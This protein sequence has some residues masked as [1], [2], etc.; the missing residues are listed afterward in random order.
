MIELEEFEIGLLYK[1]LVILKEKEET[2]VTIETD[3]EANPELPT[4]QEE[5][6]PIAEQ[7]DE[8]AL[9]SKLLIFPSAIEQELLSEQSNF[10][11]ILTALKSSHIVTHCLRIEDLKS[12]DQLSQCEVIW[13]IGLTES[14][15]DQ[16][17]SQGQ[18]LYLNSP[19]PEKL[20][21]KEEK[22]NMYAPL[23]DF[24]KHFS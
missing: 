4:K 13:S 22:L 3:Q 11:K 8:P 19:N 17:K 10:S 24:V 6:Q 1:S 2:K 23:K 16:I 18:I 20:Q 14:Q 15:Q 9:S 21:S 7:T 12:F 5:P